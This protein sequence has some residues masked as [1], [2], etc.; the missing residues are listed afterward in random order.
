MKR[1]YELPYNF[2]KKLI[3]GYQMLGITLDDIDCIYLPPFLNDY[4]TISRN[5]TFEKR[6]FTSYS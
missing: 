3:T 1:K 2:D 4:K 5:N 6:M